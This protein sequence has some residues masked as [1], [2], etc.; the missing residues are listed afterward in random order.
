[1]DDNRVRNALLL[2]SDLHAAFDAG[3]L[4]FVA[5]DSKHI[6]EVAKA[7]QCPSLRAFDGA[8]IEMPDFHRGTDIIASRDS[9]A[10]APR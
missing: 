1:M 8:V 2:R 6:V 4:W 7:V 5:V 10:L 9:L 3:R